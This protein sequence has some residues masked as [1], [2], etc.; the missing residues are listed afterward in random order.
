[1]V[2]G[3]DKL[4]AGVTFNEP[5]VQFIIKH[6]VQTEHLVNITLVPES[7]GR[8]SDRVNEG[9]LELWLKNL[10]NPILRVNF[11]AFVE[12]V[13]KTFKGPHLVVSEFLSSHTIDGAIGCFSFSEFFLGE[14]GV[15]QVDALIRR[16]LVVDFKGNSEETVMIVDNEWVSGGNQHIHS[17]VELVVLIKEKRVGDVG[18]GN[19]GLVFHTTFVTVVVELSPDLS[20]VLVE[21]EDSLSSVGTITELDNE[22]DRFLVKTLNI[23]IGV[24][25]FEEG[26]AFIFHVKSVGVREELFLVEAVFSTIL[27]SSSIGINTVDDKIFSLEDTVSG[28]VVVHLGGTVEVLS[29]SVINMDIDSLGEVVGNKRTE[30]ILSRV[31]V[32]LGHVSGNLSHG[33]NTNLSDDASSSQTSS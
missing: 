26:F 32:L 28:D 7:V 8:H 30:M 5:Q 12:V 15:G 14:M 9:L 27:E 2:I 21:D 4:W 16:V 3:S 20:L 23:L 19:D 11:T 1:V 10:F 29:N 31:E 17:K 18:L 25:V 24:N 6:E 33:I 13:S 22:L